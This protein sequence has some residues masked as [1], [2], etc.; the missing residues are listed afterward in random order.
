MTTLYLVRHA[1]SQPSPEGPEPDWPLSA[2][3]T[4]Q[5]RGLAPILAGLGIATVYCSPYRRC[6]DTLE[7]F[8]SQSGLEILLEPGL[9]ERRIAPTWQRDFRQ[10]WQRSWEDLSYALEG[11]ESSLACKA[12]IASTVE[13]I[14]GRHEGETLALGSH[15]NAIALFLHH[16]DPSVGIREAS[17]IRTPEIVRVTRSQ[18]AF[19]WDRSFSAGERFDRLATHF[20]LTP[21]VVA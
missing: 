11:G 6:R 1:Q 19:R 7:P 15:G 14:A 9:R 4:E 18:G 20:S 8:A 17:A 16:V 2:L 12:R 13:S 21:G 3:G 10:L 5:A